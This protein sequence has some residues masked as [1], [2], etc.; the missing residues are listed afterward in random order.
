MTKFLVTGATGN[1][2]RQ[3]VSQLLPRDVRALTRKPN[4]A[5]LPAG[6]DVRQGSITDIES[7]LDGVDT[8]FLMWPLHSAEPAV[9]I[10]DAIKR[11]A[12]RV[13]FLSS[14]AVTDAGNPI[15]ALHAA[16]EQAIERPGMEWTHIRPSAFAANALWWVDQIRARDVVSGI[17]GEISMAML[18]EADM[19]AVAVRALTEDGHQGKAH[20]LTGPENLSQIEQVRIIGEVLGR[21]LQWHEETRDEARRRLLDDPHFPDSFVDLLLDGYAEMRTKPPTPVTNTVMDVLGRPA[22]TF[23]EWVVDHRTDFGNKTE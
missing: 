15:G 6:V 5:R 10:V 21:P 7:A 1:V 19:A 20:A 22:R 9:S 23:R 4:T 3:V 14:G 17:C 8:V 11:H 2:G 18:H 12:R 16:V 13:V